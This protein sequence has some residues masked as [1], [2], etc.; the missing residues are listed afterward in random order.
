[1]PRITAALW[2]HRLGLDLVHVPF[3]GG[4]QSITEAIAGRVQMLTGVPGDLL[5]AAASGGLRLLAVASAERM[6][7]I[8]EV[9][10]IAESLPGFVIVNWNGFVAPTGTPQ[11]IIGRV[12]AEVAEIVRLPEVAQRLDALGNTPIGNTPAA[13]AAQMRAEA[14]LLR[15]AAQ[16]PGARDS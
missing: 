13:M 8:P 1:M 5:P 3:R 10:T 6:P 2:V 15:E 12:A 9:P 7:Q 14:P 11:P 4:A 16:G